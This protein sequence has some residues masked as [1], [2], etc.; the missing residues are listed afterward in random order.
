MKPGDNRNRRK[1][2]LGCGADKT[3]HFFIC[4]PLTAGAVTRQPMV[5]RHALNPAGKRSLFAPAET[6]ICRSVLPLSSEI[7]ASDR[8]H[9]DPFLR[10]VARLKHTWIISGCYRSSP[11][12][13]TLRRA[14]PVAHPGCPWIISR[15]LP[16]DHPGAYG[17]AVSAPFLI[18]CLRSLG[19]VS[20]LSDSRSIDPEMFI[21][22]V[23]SLYPQQ[24]MWDLKGKNAD[25]GI[26]RRRLGHRCGKYRAKPFKWCP[27]APAMKQFRLLFQLQRWDKGQNQ[28]DH[29]S[30]S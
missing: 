26:L 27:P 9:K 16:F 15:R 3:D 13:K 5:F 18:C 23:C 20:R 25:R 30:K 4:F 19:F 29:R 2:A 10:D 28:P 6:S 7:A 14:M 22:G 21:M 8:G 1:P 24:T 17:C 12:Y 11:V